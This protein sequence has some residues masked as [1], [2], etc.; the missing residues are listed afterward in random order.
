MSR[1]L[2]SCGEMLSN[3]SSPNEIVL[4][5]YTDKEWDTIFDCDSIQ[6]W[7]I[8]L[9]KNDVWKCPK[10]QR[11]YVFEKHNDTPIA[12]YTLEKDNN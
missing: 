2:C 3:S 10:C 4:R 6:P 7:L 11:V 5:V 8:P 9:P 12:I 1:M